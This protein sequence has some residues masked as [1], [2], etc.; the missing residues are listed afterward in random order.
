MNA[1]NEAIGT[2]D[3]GQPLVAGTH[4]EVDIT[5]DADS[6]S[7][8]A[9]HS[10]TEGARTS[11]SSFEDD[12]E[13]EKFSDDGLNIYSGKRYWTLNNDRQHPASAYYNYSTGRAQDSRQARER[14]QDIEFTFGQF[15]TPNYVSQKR[16]VEEAHNIAPESKAEWDE[17][18]LN[19]HYGGARFLAIVAIVNVAGWNDEE[20]FQKYQN[21]QFGDDFTQYCQEINA[22]KQTAFNKLVEMSEVGE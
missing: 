7:A 3:D 9:E 11:W 13:T 2:T 18:G 1:N 15:E 19:G 16:V 5:R 22:K 8:S 6:F 4:R 21:G 10:A 14:A 17:S 20:F 12:K